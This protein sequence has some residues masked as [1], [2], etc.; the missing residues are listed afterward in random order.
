MGGRTERAGGTRIM[1]NRDIVLMAVLECGTLDLEVLDDVEYD[2]GQIVD[3]LFESE[4]KP[5]LNNIMATVFQK[6]V[7]ELAD[8]V[9]EEIQMQL[10]MKAMFFN[11]GSMEYAKCA[12]KVKELLTLCPEEDVGYYCNCIDTSVFFEKNEELYRKLLPDKIAKVEE[13]MG[14]SFTS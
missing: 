9:E 12:E 4:I 8:Y 13:H 1:A 7:Y 2:L 6:G 14:Y 10:A 3:E 5:T 11:E